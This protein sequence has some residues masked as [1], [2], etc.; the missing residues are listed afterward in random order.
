MKDET[1]IK[2]LEAIL[3]R[4]LAWYEENLKKEES[5]EIDGSY[6]Y[7]MAY[8]VFN[9]LSRGDYLAILETLADKPLTN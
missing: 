5:G 4:Q 3:N 9:E 7:D 2:N 8:E 6:I 1:K